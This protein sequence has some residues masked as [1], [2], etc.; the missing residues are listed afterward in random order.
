[1]AAPK[2]SKK[3]KKPKEQVSLQDQLRRLGRFPRPSGPYDPMLLD[4]DLLAKRQLDWFVQRERIVET[5]RK[6]SKLGD[7]EETQA[8]NNPTEDISVDYSEG[9]K[10]A[11]KNVTRVRQSEAWRYKQL[12]PMQRQAESE[13]LLAWK[14]I[15]AG[16]GTSSSR[17][18]EPGGKGIDRQSLS[19]DIDA[20][21][22][23]FMK[24][25]RLRKINV[26]VVLECLTE[27]KTLP[28]IERAKRLRPGSALAT[29]QAG[30]DVWC[31]LRGWTRRQA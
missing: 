28:E 7:A 1:M 3:L 18:G 10:K 20:I 24:E 16:L 13:M 30:L 26:S 2:R 5:W 12:T 21:W 14:S 11:R 9:E 29:Y 15:T 17:Y 6:R 22:V 8:R 19:A 27:P 23:E 31:A 25:A 4:V